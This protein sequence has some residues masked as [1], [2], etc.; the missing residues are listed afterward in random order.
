MKQIEAEKKVLQDQL[1]ICRQEFRVLGKRTTQLEPEE[2]KTITEAVFREIKRRRGSIAS[3][4]DDISLKERRA[5]DK[6]TA[7]AIIKNH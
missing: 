4:N 7:S 6:D 3:A 1:A 5:V 2:S